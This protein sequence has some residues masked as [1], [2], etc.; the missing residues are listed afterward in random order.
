MSRTSIYDQPLPDILFTTKAEPSAALD[1]TPV[2]AT[3]TAFTEPDETRE[4]L[5]NIATLPDGSETTHGYETQQI[6]QSTT[7]TVSTPNLNPIFDHSLSPPP[8]PTTSNADRK[9]TRHGR[10]SSLNLGNHNGRLIDRFSRTG[11]RP[12][13]IYSSTKGEIATPAPPRQEV[14]TMESHMERYVKEVRAT[15]GKRVPEPTKQM[16]DCIDPETGRVGTDWV[17]FVKARVCHFVNTAASDK[18]DTLGKESFSL[19]KLRSN[20]ERLF[21]VAEPLQ[22]AA[23]RIR[24]IYRWENKLETGFYL[25]LYLLLWYEDLLLPTLLLVLIFSLLNYRIR[26]LETLDPLL[27]D[28]ATVE[29]NFATIEEKRRA[30]RKAEEQ[31]QMQ[32]KGVTDWWEDVRTSWGPFV[33]MKTG[34]FADL[35]EKIKNSTFK[36][37]VTSHSCTSLATWKRPHKT[38]LALLGLILSL[39]SFY[40]LPERVIIRA[41]LLLLGMQFFV[42]SPLQSHFPRYR[43]LF[44][45]IEWILWDVPNDAEWAMEVMRRCQG[46][47]R[48]WE[49]TDQGKVVSAATTDVLATASGIAQDICGIKTAQTG[50]A[51]GGEVGQMPSQITD[52]DGQPIPLAP[53]HAV[54]ANPDATDLSRA[55]S[56]NGSRSSEFSCGGCGPGEHVDG[57]SYGCCGLV[58]EGARIRPRLTRTS[59][60][61]HDHAAYR[62]THKALPGKIIITANC[63]MFRALKVVGGYEVDLPLEEIVGVKKSKS[64]NLLFWHT[65]G[66]EI[67]T[68][69]GRTLTFDNVAHRDECF[70]KLIAVSGKKWQKV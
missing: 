3:S 30:R 16:F 38:R 48:D 26:W 47:E 9:S 46:G 19:T 61:L 35:L 41:G 55:P 66:L 14:E 11:K 70:N 31:Q 23:Q 57:E 65:D 62:C 1:T 67:T 56:A 40:A 68:A 28:A 20:M 15:G 58:A 12:G 52:T 39:I 37:P 10:S 6:E 7:P 42:L 27:Q 51:G 43:R 25:L 60:C 49:C 18:I 32:R 44:S 17:E 59:V 22:Q 13:S 53:T 24:R 64:I 33:Q 45:I 29:S 21:T 63:L 36:H 5:G 34:D 50:G 4:F 2:V 54:D 69:D 8:S